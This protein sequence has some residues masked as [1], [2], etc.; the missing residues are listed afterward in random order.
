[1]NEIQKRALETEEWLRTPEGQKA[2]E[3]IGTK[4]EKTLIIIEEER[5]ASQEII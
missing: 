3:D 5:N 2:S 4:S 1:M